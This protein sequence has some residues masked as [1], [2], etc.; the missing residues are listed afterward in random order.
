[1]RTSQSQFYLSILS[2][3]DDRFSVQHMSIPMQHLLMCKYFSFFAMMMNA[4]PTFIIDNLKSVRI[5]YKFFNAD[6][7]TILYPIS[8]IFIEVHSIL[9]YIQLFSSLDNISFSLVYQAIFFLYFQISTANQIVSF[10][11]LFPFFSI[12]KFNY[13]RFAFFFY[14][15][16]KVYI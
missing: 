9:I 15:I 5:Q 6:Q 10:L 12:R 14:V 4:L 2:S 16:A 3:A 8:H 13:E 7:D 11:I 1:M